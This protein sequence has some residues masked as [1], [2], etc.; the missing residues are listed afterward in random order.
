[1]RKYK[2]VLFDLDGTIIN[3]G[4]GIKNGLTYAL[5]KLNFPK[6]KRPPY[7]L[8]IGPPLSESFPQYLGFDKETCNTA[9][10]YFRE[11][12]KKQ[13][14]NECELYDGVEELFIKLLNMGLK[15][16]VATSKPEIHAIPILERFKVAK[17]FEFIGG[18][19]LDEVTRAKK[20]DVILY[21]LKNI[22]VTDKAEVIM[23][24][25]RKYDVAGAN[26][27]GL[28]CIGVL[29]GFGDRK[30]LL[31]AGAKYIAPSTDDVAKIIADANKQ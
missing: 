31:E 19:T 5:D 13:G 23:V 6:E 2:Y 30:E 10:D 11:Y 26:Q 18:S 12:Y 1:M 17:Y 4:E 7:N 27:T 21:T 14:I 3:S 28:D 22:G 25:D 24:G 20:A 16:A 29:Y 9:I 15:L 8:F